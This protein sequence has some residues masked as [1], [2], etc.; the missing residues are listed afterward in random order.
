MK[1]ILVILTCFNRKFKTINCI[2][3]LLGSNKNF[4]VKFL[5]VNDGS[6]DGTK[7]ELIKLNYDIHIIEG[8]GNL[9]WNGGMR[10]GIEYALENIEADFYLLINDDVEFFPNTI[11][12][13]LGRY[14]YIRSNNQDGLIVGATCDNNNNL[15]YGAIKYV[16]KKRIKYITISPSNTIEDYDTFNCNCV[17]VPNNILRKVGNLDKKYKHSMGDFDYGFIVKRFGYCIYSSDEY[18]G[19]CERNS[20]KETWQ[21]VSLPIL[22]RLKLKESLKGLPAAQWFYFLNKNFGLY[23]AIIYSITPYIKIIT[24]R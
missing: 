1:S 11:E 14:F 9:F 2:K 24:K 16:N 5:V 15:T 13:L 12:R 3:S 23:T 22:K 19:I 7:E 8:N 21:D 10:K 20:Y 18:V 17:L 6:T 4:K